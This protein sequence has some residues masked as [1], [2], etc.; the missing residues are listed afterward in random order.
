MS[1]INTIPDINDVTGLAIM[2]SHV[3]EI[4]IDSPWAFKRVSPV[5]RSTEWIKWVYVRGDKGSVTSINL[6]LLL[7]KVALCVNIMVLRIFCEW[8]YLVLELSYHKEAIA[9]VN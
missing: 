6:V 4:M 7:L 2:I 9:S 5:E 8:A 3:N 1:Y